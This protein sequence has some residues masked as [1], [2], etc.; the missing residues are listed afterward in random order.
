MACVARCQEKDAIFTAAAICHSS[1]VGHCSASCRRSGV[2]KRR[3]GRNAWRQKVDRNCVEQ[4]SVSHVSNNLSASKLH[5]GYCSGAFLHFVALT[6]PLAG[7][8]SFILQGHCFFAF[9]FPHERTCRVDVWRRLRDV[10]AAGYGPLSVNADF[11]LRA[12]VSEKAEDPHPGRAC[13]RS[14][15]IADLYAGRHY[16]NAWVFWECF[17]AFE[18]VES[19]SAP[20]GSSRL[21]K[22]CRYLSKSCTVPCSSVV[23]MQRSTCTDNMAAYQRAEAFSR[24]YQA[25]VWPGL[26]SLSGPGSDPFHPMAR[27]ALSALDMVVDALGIGSILDAAC[28]DAGWMV[29]HFLGRRPNVQYTGI[30]I[31]KHVVDQNRE[32][33]P[34]Y[35]FLLA[36]LCNFSTGNILPQVD[37]VFSKETLNHMYVQDAVAAVRTLQTTGARY[38]VV[39]IHRGAPNLL[40]EKK[41]GHQNYAPYDFALPP[42]N[43]CKLHKLVDCNSDDWTEYSLF[44][45]Q[46]MVIEQQQVGPE[47]GSQQG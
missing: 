42:F 19:L 28:G 27:L 12:A 11:Q 8:R 9:T 41:G 18:T 30:D 5:V 32:R 2:P 45:L 44:A 6:S 7:T 37:L 39:N 24:I 23:R 1:R 46:S 14:G 29:A 26:L 21:L 38:L 35:D 13:L 17:W 25:A 47:T 40:G 10:V 22:E 31:V 15:P 33:Y 4:I 20:L 34:R 16:A 36:D 3:A 43:L